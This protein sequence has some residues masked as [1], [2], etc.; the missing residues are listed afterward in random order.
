LT[1]FCRSLSLLTLKA[2]PKAEK[3]LIRRTLRLSF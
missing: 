3:I 1:F 2:K